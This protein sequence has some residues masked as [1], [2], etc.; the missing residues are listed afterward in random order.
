MKSFWLVAAALALAP[1]AA[2]AAGPGAV[3]KQIESSMLVTGEVQIDAQGQVEKI[4]LDQPERLPAGIVKF[5]QGQV[6]DWTFEPVLV[7]GTAVPAMSRMSLR[8]IGKRLDKDSITIGIRHANFLGTEPGEG[9][10][11]SSIEMPP[12]RYPSSA[13]RDGAQ[14]S[15]YLMLRVG[16]QG[17]VED[18]VVEQI[19]LRIVGSEKQMENWRRQFA[20]A[21]LSAAR[22]WTFAP[23]TAGE[24]AGEPYWSLR[25]PVE[26]M[27]GSDAPTA[28]YGQWHTYV[29]GPRQRAPWAGEESPGFSP[30]TLAGGSVYMAGRSKGLRL[31]TRLEEG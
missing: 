19:N 23:P 20:D 21:S 13:A 27:M 31:M 16:Q 22:R 2:P 3:R 6:Q 24:L 5:V 7:G 29:P 12:P 8:V 18:V 14:G 10:A 9:E 26:Y 4:S 25:V 11:V 28:R 17:T 30:D 15:V 1:L